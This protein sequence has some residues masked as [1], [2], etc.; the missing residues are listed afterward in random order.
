MDI[1]F[2]YH[3]PS[4][5]LPEE[6]VVVLQ[7]AKDGYVHCDSPDWRA[8]TKEE[9]LI[10]F[11]QFNCFKYLS[12]ME[13]DQEAKNALITQGN[14]LRD[15]IINN[16]LRTLRQ[17]IGKWSNKPFID[18]DEITS[19]AHMWLWDAV[20]SFNYLMGNKF[21]SYL[22][23]CFKNNL[24][25]HYQRKIQKMEACQNV[26]EKIWSGLEDKHR[27]IDLPAIEA[28]FTKLSSM[29]ETVDDESAKQILLLRL[30]LSDGKVWGLEEIA[31]HMGTSPP[32]VSKRFTV[33]MTKLFGKS[34]STKILNECKNKD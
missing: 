16:N 32:N 22:H 28:G 1:P 5:D 33:W 9:E 18:C 31:A 3:E 15:R 17:T 6:Q 10:L 23:G 12:Y 34:I 13:D 25:K 20:E 26:S 14:L 27:L 19:E 24:T 8:L 21:S 7:G 4:F 29:I 11:R 30:G 2:F